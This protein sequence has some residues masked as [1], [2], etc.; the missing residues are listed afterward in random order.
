[1]G[2]GLDYRRESGVGVTLAW[3]WKDGIGVYRI[4]F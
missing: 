3:T 1:M 4:A 2:L